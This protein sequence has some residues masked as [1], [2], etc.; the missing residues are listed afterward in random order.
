MSFNH[1]IAL[2]KAMLDGATSLYNFYGK[3]SGRWAIMDTLDIEWFKDKDNVWAFKDVLERLE[4]E[5]E[6][7][8]LGPRG[9]YHIRP[10]GGS[11]EIFY[12]HLGMKKVERVASIPDHREDD[13]FLYLTIEL[14]GNWEVSI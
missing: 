3:R 14:Q 11:N 12:T 5:G 7:K 4:R 2:N 1:T 6:V 10:S 13:L 8:L 9:T